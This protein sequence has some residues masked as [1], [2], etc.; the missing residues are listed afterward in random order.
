MQVAEHTPSLLSRP[1]Q[2]SVSEDSCRARTAH[3][4]YPNSQHWL[5]SS[6][7]LATSGGPIRD[8]PSSRLTSSAPTTEPCSA[9]SSPPKPVFWNASSKLTRACASK[10][11]TASRSSAHGFLLRNGAV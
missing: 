4:R 10:E 1:R 5:K 7:P 2:Q 9:K 8:H 11:L 6:A 3:R